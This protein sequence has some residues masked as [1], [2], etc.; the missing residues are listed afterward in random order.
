MLSTDAKKRVLD[1]L[2][3]ITFTGNLRSIEEENLELTEPTRTVTPVNSL[4]T[5][6][7]NCKKGISCGN[8]CISATKTCRKTLDATAKQ[9]KKTLAEKTKKTT[10]KPVKTTLEINTTVQD[11][12]DPKQLIALGKQILEKHLVTS[13]DV[14]EEK[15]QLEK[16]IEAAKKEL[17][18]I[19]RKSTGFFDDNFDKAVELNQKII[20]LQEEAE[21][22]EIN[23]V[24][25]GVIGELK[26]IT[27][28]K[29][30]KTPDEALALILIAGPDAATKNLEE[31]LRETIAIAGMPETLTYASIENGRSYA[32]F[33]G[34]VVRDSKRAQF[35]EFAHHLEFSDPDSLTALI[36][37]RN[38][39]ATGS[40]V[41][42]NELEKTDTYDNDEIAYPDKFVTNYVGKVYVYGANN[43]ATEVYS[44]GFEVFHDPL[45]FNNLRVKDPEH[46][47]LIIGAI[48]SKPA[49][50]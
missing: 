23:K 36:N 9:K 27:A 10:K 30:N 19:N 49:N 42:L 3:Y 45:Y 15:K 6:A 24:Y 43:Y 25:S 41:L 8:A 33:D 5:R 4:V 1:E 28:S 48:A 37:W 31:N 12:K 18:K 20:N 13:Q 39:R 14:Q 17:A 29:Q 16:E 50:K 2:V 40:A 32:Q 38:G 7:K 47:E 21:T 34:I 22:L 26:A 46:L 35:H 11:R 44:V